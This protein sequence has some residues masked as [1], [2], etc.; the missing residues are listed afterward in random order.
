MTAIYVPYYLLGGIRVKWSETDHRHRHIVFSCLIRR[1]LDYYG[2]VYTKIT[3]TYEANPG[4]MKKQTY[5]I[6]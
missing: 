3:G 6:A 1:F 5:L 2:L 4:V